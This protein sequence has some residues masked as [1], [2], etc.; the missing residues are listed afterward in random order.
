M[1]DYFCKLLEIYIFVIDKCPKESFQKCA[2]I[3]ETIN[4]I[5]TKLNKKNGGLEK[6]YGLYL[7]AIEL[8]VNSNSQKFLISFVSISQL[9]QLSALITQILII[10]EKSIDG[11][12]L[13]R[14]AGLIEKI[15]CQDVK[16]ATLVLSAIFPG[17]F[18]KLRSVTSNIKLSIS[19]RSRSG[20]HGQS[21]LE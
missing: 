14:C 8:L 21:H 13:E 17:V 10:I 2:P 15:F 9:P 7:E 4:Q 12:I 11:N 6:V 3:F 19:I 16:E 20:V 5:G 1:K 18:A